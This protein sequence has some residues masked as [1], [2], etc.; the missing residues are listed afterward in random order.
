MCNCVYACL[1]K[2][3]L[4]LWAKLPLKNK[5]DDDDDS[6]DDDDCIDGGKIQSTHKYD[7]VALGAYLVRFTEFVLDRLQVRQPDALYVPAARSST[8]LQLS[9]CPTGDHL[10]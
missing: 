2:T 4:V 9:S 10:D 7:Q 3:F 8:R 6:D 1:I 5:F